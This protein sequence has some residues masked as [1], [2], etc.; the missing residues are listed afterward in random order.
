MNSSLKISFLPFLQQILSQSFLYTLNAWLLA[1][2]DWLSFD[3]ALGS[4]RLI[5][6]LTDYRLS[7][8]IT[9]YMILF[10]LFFKG[11]QQ[12]HVALALTIIPFLPASG[13]IKLGFVI[14]ERILYL[15]SMGFCLLIAIGF[16][17]LCKCVRSAAIAK[18][19]LYLL[20]IGLVLMF[21]LKTRQRAHE[22][23]TEHLLFSSALRVCPNNAKIYY[24]IARLASDRNDRKTAFQYYNKAI[25]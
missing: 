11:N 4:I 3:W 17:R 1:C 19:M 21:G 9:L 12:V 2:P 6:S 8:I 25:R 24:N 7:A 14:A 15:P 23:T 10:S 5:E 18:S 16:D 13:I 22:W 20:L